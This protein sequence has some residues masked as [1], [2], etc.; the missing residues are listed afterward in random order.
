MVKQE[1]KMQMPIGT[2][3]Q[4]AKRQSDKDQN[5][6]FKLKKYQNVNKERKM[7]KKDS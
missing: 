4:W 3:G 5:Q 1:N 7:R 2:N 6:N